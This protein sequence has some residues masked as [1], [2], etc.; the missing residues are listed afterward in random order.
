MKRNLSAVFLPICVV[1]I[2]YNIVHGQTNLENREIL[3]QVQHLRNITLGLI[4]SAR[5]QGQY[6][7]SAELGAASELAGDTMIQGPHEFDFAFLSGD[8]IR[9]IRGVDSDVLLGSTLVLGDRYTKYYVGQDAAPTAVRI[10]RDITEGKTNLM[11]FDHW[12]MNEP[13]GFPGHLSEEEQ[14]QRLVELLPD[15]VIEREGAIVRLRYERDSDN[16]GL[17]ERES[18]T[19]TTHVASTKEIEFDMS[20]GGMIQQYTLYDSRTRNEETTSRYVEWQVD[21]SSNSEGLPIPLRCY[22]SVVTRRNEEL[23][24]DCSLEVGFSQFSYEPVDRS[25][26][27]VDNLQ[28]P[29]GTPVVDDILGIE[30]RYSMDTGATSGGNPLNTSDD[31]LSVLEEN[32]F[33]SHTTQMETNV[34]DAA[35]DAA[36][37]PTNTTSPEHTIPNAP[38]AIP[39]DTSNET[40]T[41]ATRAEDKM[42]LGRL[43]WFLLAGMALLGMIVTLVVRKQAVR[44]SKQ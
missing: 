14:W 31:V 36:D 40:V 1:F 33:E 16:S 38:D 26:L 29:V 34:Q 25:E 7:V 32:S 39:S 24:S 20:Q 37:V 9:W 3:E 11:S 12:R 18:A 43:W 35:T 27:S 28:I 13:F 23:L 22:S 8:S 42:V 15:C 4:S 10:G 5:G 41:E 6:E 17:S 19:G 21:W 2:T 44:G 30:Y